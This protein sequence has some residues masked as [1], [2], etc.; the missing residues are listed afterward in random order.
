M[1]DLYAAYLER[2]GDYGKAA[3]EVNVMLSMY[4]DDDDLKGRLAGLQAKMATDKAPEAQPAEA[5]APAA[6]N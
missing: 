1:V 3:E 4:P 6:T 2:T 5:I